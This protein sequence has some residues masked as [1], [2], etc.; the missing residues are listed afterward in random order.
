VIVGVQTLNSLRF[1]DN[2]GLIAESP[3]QLQELTAEE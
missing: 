1:A 2:T 3:E